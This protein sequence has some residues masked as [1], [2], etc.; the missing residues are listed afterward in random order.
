MHCYTLVHYVFVPQP[1]IFVEIS[2]TPDILLFQSLTLIAFEFSRR[3]N[4]VDSATIVLCLLVRSCRLCS[5]VFVCRAA[6]FYVALFK[7]LSNFNLSALFQVDE[8]QK[9]KRTFRKFTFRGVDLDQL[10]DMP[11]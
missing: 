9:K 3:V 6:R 8:G 2:I 11:A 1:L 7:L 5:P 4:Y 10:L